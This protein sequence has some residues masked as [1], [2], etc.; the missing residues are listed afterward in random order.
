MNLPGI[1]AESTEDD[2]VDTVRLQLGS[3]TLLYGHLMEGDRRA[4]AESMS[5][6]LFGG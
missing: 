5:R 2:Y 3:R 1:V 4:A 6:A